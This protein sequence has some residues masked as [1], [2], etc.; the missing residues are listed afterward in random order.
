M[1]IGEVP[2]MLYNIKYKL[3]E[4]EDDGIDI[5]DLAKDVIVYYI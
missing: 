1:D 3:D 2:G 5:D 4:R